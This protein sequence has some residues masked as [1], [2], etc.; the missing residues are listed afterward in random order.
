MEGRYKRHVSR[1]RKFQHGG[2]VRTLEPTPDWILA[3]RAKK[4]L[5]Y[6]FHEKA[7]S[8]HVRG[9]LC[10]WGAQG[11]VFWVCWEC[12]VQ[13]REQGGC[14]AEQL[15]AA[16]ADSSRLRRQAWAWFIFRGV[17]S[18]RLMSSGAAVRNVDSEFYNWQSK[19]IYA[20]NINDFSVDII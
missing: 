7:F 3:S 20:A 16:I 2:Q 6:I 11:I 1:H 13:S 5:G 19:F 12:Q 9:C 10:C 4:P 14:Q 18:E 17:R 15:W 8:F